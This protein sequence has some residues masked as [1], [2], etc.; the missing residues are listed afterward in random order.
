MSSTELERVEIVDGES[1]SVTTEATALS[2]RTI[3]LRQRPWRRTPW[4]T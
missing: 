2:Q 3:R 1:W 4:S